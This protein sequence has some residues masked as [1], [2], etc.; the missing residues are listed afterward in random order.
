MSIK[1]REYSTRI[2]DYCAEDVDVWASAPCPQCSKDYC[3]D[4]GGHVSL[5][6]QFCAR[7][8]WV[9]NG[10]TN[11]DGGVLLELCHQCLL[12]NNPGLVQE[13]A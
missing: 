3:Q 2:C 1:L 13:A 11:Y 5:R 7:D 12:A 6:G 8:P 4:H 9:G 10:A